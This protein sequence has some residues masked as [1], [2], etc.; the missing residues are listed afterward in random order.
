MLCTGVE[1]VGSEVL[2]AIDMNVAILWDIAACCPYVNRRFGG[3]RTTYELHGVISQKW[4]IHIEVHQPFLKG[5]SLHLK[6]D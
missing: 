6:R 5:N 1:V 3:D 2:A 4:H